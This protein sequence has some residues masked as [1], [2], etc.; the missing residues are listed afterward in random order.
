[1]NE[2]VIK[3]L[4][5]LGY[6]NI[7]TSYYKYTEI[8]E[9]WFKNDL[10]FH[11]YYDT[12]GQERK[13]FSLGMAKRLCEDWASVIYGERDEITTDNENNK[14]YIEKL[15][16]DMK[17]GK[18]IPKAIEKASW[19][20]TCGSVFRI[21][22]AKVVNNLL[23]ADDKTTMDLIKV[24]AKNIIPLRVE[25]GVI[26]DVA[27]CS[28]TNVGD[29]KAIYVEIHQLLESGYKISNIYLEQDNGNIIENKSVLKSFET[30]STTPLFSVLMTPKEN[31]IEDNNGLG[32]SIYGDAIDQLKGC[33]I[34]YHNFMQDFVLG[35]KKLIYNKKL[36]R[37]ETITYTDTNNKTVTREVPIYPDDISK[38]QFMEVGD[39]FSSNDDKKLIHEYNPD[40]RVDDNQKGLQFAL[41]LLSFK[42][43]LGTKKYQFNGGSIV[44]ATQYVGEQQDLIQ[45]AKKYR[46]NLT[47]Y[48]SGIIKAGL[49]IGRL[50]FKENVTEECTVL[51]D[52]VDGFMKDDE[53]IKQSA[54]EDLALGVISKVEY[55]MNV[56][57]ET[58]EVAKEMLE[59]LNEENTISNVSL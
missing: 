12:Y 44:T 37:Y 36:I 6:N 26:I 46:D 28:K 40:L 52:N 17:L 29:L 54:R 22:N 33:D 1:M 25:H 35:G 49:L 23:V 7:P 14:K 39:E 43:G 38:Q 5:T 48:I 41:D 13:M 4:G 30:G 55:R 21:K 9:E 58:E 16:K 18:E 10:E 11:K 45:N 57:H 53:S 56:Y 50:I 2:Y 20:G 3:Y 27:F 8:W 31:P 15:V 19:S 24:S 32:F 51:I 47:E 59:K 42:G 34:T